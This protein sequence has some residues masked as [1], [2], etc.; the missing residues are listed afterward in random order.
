MTYPFALWL[1]KQPNSEIPFMVVFY[2]TFCLFW[3]VLLRKSC[4]WPIYFLMGLLTGVSMLIRP[5]AIGMGVVMGAILGLAGQ[6]M[7]V[8]SR[9]FLVAMILL[10]NLVA[11]FPWEAWVYSKTGRVVLLSTNGAPSMYDGLTFALDL[12]GYRQGI[13][14]PQDVKALMH[15]IHAR[16]EMQ[17]LGGVLS[18]MAEELQMRPL[19]VAKLLAIKTARSWYA[20]DSHRFETPIMLMQIVY[21]ILIFWSSKV[22]WK[23]G[24]I[25]KQLA[26]SV[27]LMILYFWGITILSL[28]IFRYIVPVMGLLF[29]LLPALCQSGDS[30]P[31]RHWPSI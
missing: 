5:M 11:I 19:A 3:H 17:S 13:A 10:G 24:G 22:A 7:I 16:G 27:W 1:T 6:G 23:Q 12:K 30:S 20:T 4:A 29:L 14:L 15:G 26:V 21:L 25:A 9:L 28:S 18:V 8:R 31:Y 2:G